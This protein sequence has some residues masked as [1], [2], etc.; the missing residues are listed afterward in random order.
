MRLAMVQKVDL[1]GRLIEDE[2]VNLKLH[3]SKEAYN[4]TD[5][6]NEVSPVVCLFNSFI[7]S[8]QKYVPVFPINENKALAS[9]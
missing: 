3:G 6:A 1:F 8:S 9:G 5:L 2:E 7:A 4:R